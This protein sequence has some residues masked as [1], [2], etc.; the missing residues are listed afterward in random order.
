MALRKRSICFT[1]MESGGNDFIIIDNRKKA[2]PRGLSRLA[3]NLC[4]RRSSIG[5]DGLILL[6]RAEKADYR[7]RIFNP[8]GSEPE[9]C[10][11]G[12]RCLAR[13]AFI[14]GIASAE[15]V[16]K[17]RA[18]N[19]QAQVKGKKVKVKLGNPSDINLNFKISLK[20]RGSKKINFINIG[21]PHAVIFVPALN[22]VD[23]KNLGRAI[24]YHQRFVPSGANV[25]FVTVQGK[26]SIYIRTYERGVE[27]ETLACGTG[28]VASALI[29]GLK[30]KVSSPV[31][32]RT[33][34]GE[35]L[36]V[37]YIIEKDKVRIGKF[38]GVW[39]EGE[40]RVV[41]EGEI[42]RD[43]VFARIRV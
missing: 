14:K 43:L 23:V 2:L 4:Q 18:G 36:K 26:N 8:D 24:R 25:N 6:E 40:V 39:L 5:A 30:G 12:A 3:V 1:K 33:R 13:F 42:A 17:T 27:D 31:Q 15:A 9:M 16:I 10:G 22:K 28:A 7:M 29:S 20:S 34:G 37:E 38:K 11:N 35:T 19:V 21:V 32:V 41:Y